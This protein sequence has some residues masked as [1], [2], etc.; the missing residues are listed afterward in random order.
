M[1]DVL[2]R[3]LGCRDGLR[4]K[5]IADPALGTPEFEEKGHFAKEVLGI[6]D[7]GEVRHRGP[8]TRE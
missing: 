3:D 5:K 1:R 7:W 6:K 2:R 8:V 4:V